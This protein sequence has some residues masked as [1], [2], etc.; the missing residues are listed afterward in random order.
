[1]GLA[2]RV[3]QVPSSLI[4]VPGVSLAMGEDG[5]GDVEGCPTP[6]RVRH[7]QTARGWQGFGQGHGV[8]GTWGQVMLSLAA[9]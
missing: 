3:R 1:M 4:W 9:A 5:P 8:H 2:A 6:S 7:R